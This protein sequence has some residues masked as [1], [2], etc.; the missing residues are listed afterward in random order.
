MEFV[1]SLLRKSDQLE[2]NQLRRCS[3]HKKYVN[4]VIL[5]LTVGPVSYL[6][7]AH[8][9]TGTTLAVGDPSY[10]GELQTGSEDHPGKANDESVQ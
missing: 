3:V 7:S 9:I 2:E 4:S 1:K 5:N 8:Q 10:F 6:C